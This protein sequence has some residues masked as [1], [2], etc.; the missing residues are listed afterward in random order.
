MTEA[1]DDSVAKRGFNAFVAMQVMP[2]VTTYRLRCRLVGEER[3]YLELSERGARWTGIRGERARLA[4]HR[5]LGTP[6]G[7]AVI[8]RHGVILERPPLSVGRMT[9]VMHFSNVQH[10]S[11]GADCLI[12]DHV[13]I[14]DGRRQHSIDRLDVPINQQHGTVT[15]TQIGDDVLIGAGSTVLADVGNHGVVGAG[16]VVI[17]PVPAYKIA[18]GNPARIIGDR[19]ER[20]GT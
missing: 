4:L 17:A 9:V 13:L 7:E 11:I 19:R 14:V 2:L 15:Q 18:A 12:G 3:A 8:L 10:A 16:S 1:F 20:R 6:I 5:M